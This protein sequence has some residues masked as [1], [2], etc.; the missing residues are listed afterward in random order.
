[1]P[2]GDGVADARVLDV[3]AIQRVARRSFHAAY[4]DLLG[5]S[6]VDAVLADWY[7]TER[8]REQVRDPGIAF[9]VARLGRRVR[10]FADVVDHPDDPEGAFLSRLYVEPGVWGQGVGSHLLST[11]EDRADDR[12][13]LELTVLADNERAIEFYRDR[14]FREVDTTTTRLA[15]HEIEER[16]FREEL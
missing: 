1:M 8:V 2:S 4:D 13:W 15:Y 7:V 6:L 14:G 9:V 12:E 16:V 5:E 10:G 3:P 11:V